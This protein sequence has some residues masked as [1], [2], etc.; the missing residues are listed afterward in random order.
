[1]FIIIYFKQRKNYDKNHK[2]K[3]LNSKS[4]K[5]MATEEVDSIVESA[6]LLEM[7]INDKDDN[8]INDNISY[9]DE[10]DD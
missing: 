4:E 6:D 7:N 5:K 9:Y 8:V 2:N 3:K 10:E 1:M